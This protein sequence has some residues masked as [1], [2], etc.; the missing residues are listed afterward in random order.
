MPFTCMTGFASLYNYNI[1]FFGNSVQTELL[2]VLQTNVATAKLVVGQFC[3]EACFPYL[4]NIILES[5]SDRL[6]K[7]IFLN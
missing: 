7:H 6:E 1:K 3:H 4:W 2:K 5:A